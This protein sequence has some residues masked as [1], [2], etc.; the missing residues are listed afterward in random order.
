[1]IR[2]ITDITLNVH[3]C[4]RKVLRKGQKPWLVQCERWNL[5]QLFRMMILYLLLF[6]SGVEGNAIRPSPTAAQTMSSPENVTWIRNETQFVTATNQ[7][8]D[9]NEAAYL[10]G[11][12]QL[13]ELLG[14]LQMQLHQ[15]TKKQE[16]LE[17]KTD[18]IETENTAL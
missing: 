12:R 18:S 15:L 9:N 11:P 13:K 3:C 8:I 17:N 2:G 16:A 4:F 10:S 14:P 1:M 6:Q 5:N 7:P